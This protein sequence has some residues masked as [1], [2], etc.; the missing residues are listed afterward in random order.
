MDRNDDGSEKRV[1]LTIKKYYK[2]TIDTHLPIVTKD[3]WN[4]TNE[5]YPRLSIV[6]CHH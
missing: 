5:A 3:A 6:F 1:A 2:K 4:N